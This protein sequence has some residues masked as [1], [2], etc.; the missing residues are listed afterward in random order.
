MVSLLQSQLLDFA[1]GAWRELGVPAVRRS[2]EHWLIDPEAL[3]VLTANLAGLD[4]RLRDEALSW[5]AAS[6]ALLSRQRLR[7][8]LR[9]WPDP[10]GWPQ[11]AAALTA[12]TGVAWPHAAGDNQTTARHREAPD[13]WDQPSQLRLRSRG[14][15][16]VGARAEILAAMLTARGVGLTA[17]ELLEDTCYSKRNLADALAAME[18]AGLLTRHRFGAQ[19]RYRL[20]EREAAERILGPLPEVALPWPRLLA[21]LLAVDRVAEHLPGRASPAV[22]AVEGRRAVAEL[23]LHVLRGRW[24]P[25]VD[26][27][28]EALGLATRVAS[29]LGSAQAPDPADTPGIADRLARPVGSESFDEEARSPGGLG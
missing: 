1:W 15:I 23:G 22:R 21:E 5:S 16:G 18:V 20:R 24:P 6:T 10:K 11:F 29:A 27:V 14:A 3:L 8:V 7:G 25:E 9:V 19:L 2:H 28:Q 4:P 17:A 26:V 12:V 13:R